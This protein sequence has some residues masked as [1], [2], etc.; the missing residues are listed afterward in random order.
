MY[1]LAT[2]I[3]ATGAALALGS[4][5]AQ[6]APAGEVLPL[7]CG[8]DGTYSVFV[9][10]NGEFT[11]ARDTRSTMVVVPVSFQGFHFVATAA[12]GTV[13]VDDTDASVTSKGGGNP[14]ARS[15]RR[16]VTCTFSQSFTLTEADDEFPAGTT[17]DISGQVTGYLTPAK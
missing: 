14:A 12:D 15:P 2:T 10:G 9:N 16:Q 1:R 17:L 5:P 4:L 13:L 8:A 11:P 7:D 3:A 6:A